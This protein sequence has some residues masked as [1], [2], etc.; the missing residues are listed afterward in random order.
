MPN[1]QRCFVQ[2]KLDTNTVCHLVLTWS[3]SSGHKTSIQWKNW[4]FCAWNHSRC[5][6]LKCIKMFT[7]EYSTISSTM[8]QHLVKTLPSFFVCR[9]LICMHGMWHTFLFSHYS[10]E[11]QMAVMCKGKQKKETMACKCL[12][13]KKWSLHTFSFDKCKDAVS[14]C[15]NVWWAILT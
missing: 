11:L 10:T 8:E 7:V 15:E 2:S 3:G 12:R 4:I 1:K 13:R 5:S 14:M 9:L 6:C